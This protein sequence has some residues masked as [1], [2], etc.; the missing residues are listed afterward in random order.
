MTLFMTKSLTISQYFIRASFCPKLLPRKTNCRLRF[1]GSQQLFANFSN[2]GK[3]MRWVYAHSFKGEP[4]VSDFELV[5]EDVPPVKEGEVKFE[6]L[7][8]SVDPYMR[9]YVNK[10]GGKT[11][12][13]MFGGQVARVVE[14]KHPEYKVGSIV[15]GQLGWQLFTVG[16]PEEITTV[17]GAKEKPM[18]LP[19]LGGLSPSLALGVLGMP[20]NTA[21]FG[22]LEICKPVAGETVVVSGAA[23]AVGSLVGQIAKIKG[24]RVIGIAGS[25][26]KVA[27]LKDELKF[28]GAINYKTQNVSAELKKL[29]PKGVDCYFDNVGGDISS[30]VLYQ[31]NKY[32][33]IS[34][35]GAISVYNNDFSNLAKAPVIQTAMVMN[36]LKMEGFI[37]MRWAHRWMEGVLQNLKWVKEGELKYKETVTEGFKKMPE[38]FIGM[39][40]GENV[41]KAVV[42]A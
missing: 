21:Y 27:W 26:D 5:E 17:F 14:S 8:L 10:L 32:G 2:M 29:A 22:F 36:E 37:V 35:C 16:N 30:Q 6:A 3:N 42:K 25:D 9:A 20:G 33:R 39:L 1:S 34:V 24:C 13:T 7:Y 15:V 41:G 23:G 19:D 12:F 11:G 40:R 4:K 38:A 18:V 28:D 31:M